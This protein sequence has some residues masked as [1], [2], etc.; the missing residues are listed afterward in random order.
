[1]IQADT[2]TTTNYHG[3]TY[4]QM[5][6]DDCGTTGTSCESGWVYYYIPAFLTEKSGQ[7]IAAIPERHRSVLKN[8]N[9]QLAFAREI[10]WPYPSGFV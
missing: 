3:D 6:C 4:D 9:M 2:Y 1:M 10:M 5:I 7:Y 8:L